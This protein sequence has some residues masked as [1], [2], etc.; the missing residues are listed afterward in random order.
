[1][2]FIGQLLNRKKIRNTYQRFRTLII[3]SPYQYKYQ[4]IERSLVITRVSYS[5]ILKI[6]EKTNR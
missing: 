4:I 1:M 3:L 2:T 5:E 6:V